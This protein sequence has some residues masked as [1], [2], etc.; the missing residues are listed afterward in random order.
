MQYFYFHFLLFGLSKKIVQAKRVNEKIKID[1]VLNE[2]LW[3]GNGYS[4]FVQLEPI[5]GNY[6][7]RQKSGLLTMGVF[8]MLPQD[9]MTL[10]L[11]FTSSLTYSFSRTL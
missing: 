2:D 4:D 11:S 6:Q 8:Y 10:N 1:G 7:K 5:D 9:F 3:R